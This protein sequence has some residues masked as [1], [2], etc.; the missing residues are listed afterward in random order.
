[1]GT[2]YVCMHVLEYN[3][4]LKSSRPQE[5]HTRD[6]YAVS[7]SGIL[8]MSHVCSINYVRFLLK[9]ENGARDLAAASAP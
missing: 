5:P 3:M 1:M 2:Q 4:C 6:P 7:V 8:Q 9:L